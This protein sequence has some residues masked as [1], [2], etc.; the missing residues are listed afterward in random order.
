MPNDP[1]TTADSVMRLSYPSHQGLNHHCSTPDCLVFGAVFLRVWRDSPPALAMGRPSPSEVGMG[2][3]MPSTQSGQTVIESPTVLHLVG[4]ATSAFYHDLSLVYARE[5]LLP[6][7]MQHRFAV[8]LPNGH[9]QY[10]PSL[11]VL[12]PPT[13]LGRLVDQ[14]T[15]ADLVVPYMFDPIG[16]TSYRSLFEDVLRVPVVGSRA[17]VTAVA[18]DKMWTKQ[19]LAEAGVPVPKTFTADRST[20]IDYPVIVKPNREDNSRGLTLVDDADG[21]EAAVEGAGTFEAGVLIEEYIPGRELRVAVVDTGD[22]LYVPAIIEYGVTPDHPIRELD[23]KLALDEHGSP[24]AQSRGDQVPTIC[25]AEVTP[26]LRNALAEQ[27]RAAHLA[28]GCRDYSLFD[29]RVDPHE[30]PW[31]LEAGL[32]WTFGRPSMISKMI[33]ADG[34]D[35]ETIATEVWRR[36]MHRR[37]DQ[38]VGCA[39]VDA[40]DQGGAV[41]GRQPASAS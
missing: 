27:A 6:V 23:H 25:P 40:L 8:V 33:A 18:T 26:A 35:T 29:F 38:I 9:W 30:R 4:S 34:R 11:D 32:F 37:R 5:A 10:G 22:E 21:L 17:E 28:L 7:S 41:V 39:D 1:N 12:S 19:V 15:A 3:I 31:L 13:Q 36:A 2:A 24:V 16:M 20:A 14:L